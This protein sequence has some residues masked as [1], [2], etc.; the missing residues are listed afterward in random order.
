[1]A[2]V[3]V[4]AAADVGDSL[5]MSLRER[6]VFVETWWGCCAEGGAGLLE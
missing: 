4:E 5:K 3:P 2:V 1:M 6:L